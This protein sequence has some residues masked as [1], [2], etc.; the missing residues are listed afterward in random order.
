MPGHRRGH[1]SVH[2]LRATRIGT[3]DRGCQRPHTGHLARR[4]VGVERDTDRARLAD[5]GRAI[6]GDHSNDD[7]IHP[8]CYPIARHSVAALCIGQMYRPAGDAC[9]SHACHS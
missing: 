4:V 8:S 2:R 3:D 9:D 1:A 5:T 7:R 6:V